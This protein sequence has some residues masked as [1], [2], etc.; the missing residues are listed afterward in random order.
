[1]QD[2]FFFFACY[3]SVTVSDEREVSAAA[4]V[5]G[6]LM[7]PSVQGLRLLQPQELWPYQ[8][9]FSS[10]SWQSEDLFGWSFFVAPPFQVLSGLP[11]QGYFSVV[12]CLSTTGWRPTL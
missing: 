5:A 1:M 7:V 6:T 12:C 9:L 11:C 10:R 4:W 3:S 8:S 2:F